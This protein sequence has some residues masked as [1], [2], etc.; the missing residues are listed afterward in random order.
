MTHHLSH[1]RGCIQRD[2]LEFSFISKIL[3]FDTDQKRNYTQGEKRTLLLVRTVKTSLNV[4]NIFCHFVFFQTT[5]GEIY[6]RRMLRIC[7][8]A[9]KPSLQ[10][11]TRWKQSKFQRCL[12][13]CTVGKTLTTRRHLKKKRQ[14][15]SLQQVSNERKCVTTKQVHPYYAKVNTFP[16]HKA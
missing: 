16:I 6:S 12:G 8:I 7:N 5:S 11:E 10:I 9:A 4:Q 2:K 15:D 13:E 14:N 3:H 1:G